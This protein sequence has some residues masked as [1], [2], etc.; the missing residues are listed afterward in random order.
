MRGLGNWYKRKGSRFWWIQFYRRG[1]SHQ[2]STRSESVQDAQKLLLQRNTESEASRSPDSPVLLSDLFQ[3]LECD[4]RIRKR[5]TLR[6]IQQ[7]WRNHLG[8]A[9][10]S[11]P[12][13]TISHKALIEYGIKRQQDG[14]ANATINREYAALKRM[15]KLGLISADIKNPPF[16]PHL[17]EDNVRSGFLPVEKYETLAAE[18]ARIGLWLRGLFELAYVCGCRKGALLTLRVEQ[19]DLLAGS[20]TMHPGTG[21]KRKP[22][23]LFMTVKVRE[24]LI[25]CCAGKAPTDL[26]FTRELQANKHKTRTEGGRIADLRDSWKKACIAA[27]VE[28]LRLHDLRRTALTNMD[29]DGISQETAMRISGHQTTSSYRRYL[30]GQDGP[31]REAALKMERGARERQK[32]AV[33]IGI[34][35]PARPV[36]GPAKLQ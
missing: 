27:G 4:Y 20:I 29:A 21:T 1:K 26:V 32:K 13:E 10:G 15:Y 30:I 8:P 36:R 19:V 3:A 23:K 33:Q 6:N 11:R 7:I 25:E 22:S 14:A 24:L 12:A 34:F 18:C 31:L 5:K 16:V 2:E 9:F 28:G 35:D 17:E